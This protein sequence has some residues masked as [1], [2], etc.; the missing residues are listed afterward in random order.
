[1]AMRRSSP[2]PRTIRPRRRRTKQ[3][4]TTDGPCKTSS[5]RTP[6]LKANVNLDSKVG[7]LLLKSYDGPLTIEAIT[8]EA[9]ELGCI[10]AARD[11]QTPPSLE[12]RE[13]ADFAHGAEPST[14]LPQKHPHDVAREVGTE[15]LMTGGT[16]EDAIRKGFGVLVQGAINGDPRVLVAPPPPNGV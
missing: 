14:A 6:S 11:D 7:Q 2:I 16:T 8:A 1:M 3:C 13:R 9:T 4:S 12:A 5:E 15:V 10:R